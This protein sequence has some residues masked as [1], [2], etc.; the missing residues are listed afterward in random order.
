[1]VG[2]LDNGKIIT[3]KTITADD[4]G[5]FVKF[6]KSTKPQFECQFE[7]NLRGDIKDKPMAQL[8]VVLGEAALKLENVGARKTRGKKK[9]LYQFD[10]QEY[11]ALED[12]MYHRFEI[13]DPWRWVEDL[14]F[15]KVVKAD[16]R[17]TA[18]K[19]RKNFEKV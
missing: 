5:D 2:L 15:E 6:V 16:Q 13:N 9:Y 17:S 3:D 12:I 8:N 18:G 1:M 14:M 10:P 19:M 4:L 11:K 7:S